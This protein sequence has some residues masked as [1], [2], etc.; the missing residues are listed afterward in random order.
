MSK[1][2]TV[3]K[4]AIL[5]IVLTGVVVTVE[6]TGVLKESKMASSAASRMDELA[7]STSES[8]LLFQGASLTL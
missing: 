6:I 2:N 1:A 5:N 8:S 3:T 4:H 7:N